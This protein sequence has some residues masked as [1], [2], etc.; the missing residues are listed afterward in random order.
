MRSKR[1]PSN[2]INWFYWFFSFLIFFLCT[3]RPRNLTMSLKNCTRFF[4]IPGAVREE[5]KRWGRVR[6]D[7]HKLDV[8]RDSEMEITLNSFVEP[9]KIFFDRKISTDKNGLKM[10]FEKSSYSS[11]RK[12]KSESNN[13]FCTSA[14]EKYFSIFFKIS[15]KSYQ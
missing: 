10:T 12:A 7:A 5:G 6:R 9:Q 1:R 2:N 13:I 4:R 8:I 15:L 3:V 14:Y 11:H